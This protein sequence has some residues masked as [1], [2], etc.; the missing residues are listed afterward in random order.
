MRLAPGALPRRGVVTQRG[1]TSAASVLVEWAD[2]EQERVKA[3]DRSVGYAVDGTRSLEWLLEPGLVEEDLE[4]D[5]VG[6]FVNIIRDSR[7]ITKLML[8][9]RLTQLGVDERDVEHMYVE[10]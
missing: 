6:V 5:P 10:A 7:K 4:A 2:G 3:S 1:K 8:C 9:R